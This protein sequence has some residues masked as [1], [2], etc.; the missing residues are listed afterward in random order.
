VTVIVS[1]PSIPTFLVGSDFGNVLCVLDLSRLPEHGAV[2]VGGGFEATRVAGADFN[3]D[4]VLDSVVG[5]GVGTP[6]RVAS[7]NGATEVTVATAAPFEESFTGGVFVAAG[8][9][10]G[11]GTPDVAVGAD[12]GGGSRVVVYLGRP[13]QLVPAISFDPFGD[14]RYRGGV[15]VALGDVNGDGR[16]DLVCAPGKDGGPRVAT[17]DGR[18]L[19]GGTAVRLWNDF[20][21]FDEGSRVGAFVAAGD[22]NGDGRAEVIVGADAGGS[23]RVNVFDGATLASSGQP[24]MTANFFSGSDASRGG[25]RV[26]ARDVTGDGR[27]DLITGAGL[28]EGSRVRVY[29]GQDVSASSAPAPFFE[30]DAIPGLI[31]GVYVG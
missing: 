26:A 23:A 20:Y 30:T 31:G 15:R 27:A 7:V 18:A 6:P 29:S 19:A 22:L 10:D 9:I 13:G 3:D 14:P 5:S 8:D 2:V 24:N 1:E 12:V 4:G 16:A 25:V 21:A 11:D 28:G 17:F